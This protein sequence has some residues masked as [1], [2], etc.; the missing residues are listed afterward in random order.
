[1]IN[2]VPQNPLGNSPIY[3]FIQPTN[4]FINNFELEITNKEID[5]LRENTKLLTDR[6]VG[7]ANQNSE[8]HSNNI[9]K[10]PIITL[11]NN[12][13][14]EEKALI[15]EEQ[16]RIIDEDIR[17]TMMGNSSIET[18]SL[19]NNHP[20]NPVQ[21]D[22]EKPFFTYDDKDWKYTEGP[23]VPTVIDKTLQDL[24]RKE[25]NHQ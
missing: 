23:R 18:D 7:D 11:Q 2:T 14:K 21:E 4:V 8:N 6:N 24:K 25:Q 10:S 5:M 17:A 15:D 19:P 3:Q 20:S 13:S 9:Q 12:L 16:A 22:D 1:L